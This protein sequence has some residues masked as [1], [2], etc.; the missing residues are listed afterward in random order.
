[1]LAEAGR[2]EPTRLNIARVYDYLL[3]GSHNFEAGRAAAAQSQARWPDARHTMAANCPSS[4]EPE[5]TVAPADVRSLLCR[6]RSWWRPEHRH[7]GELGS[8][9]R[10]GRGREGAG[11]PADRR[12]AGTVRRSCGTM[13]GSEATAE[14]CAPSRGWIV[15]RLSSGAE[16]RACRRLPEAC[17]D[18]TL[19]AAAASETKTG[20]TQAEQPAEPSRQ[21]GHG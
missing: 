16:L 7:H 5:V 13:R 9:D 1:M 11:G 18:T 20:I 8:G 10:S 21:V 17:R 15:I 4:P 19:R 6:H 14:N 2:Q 3:D 12:R